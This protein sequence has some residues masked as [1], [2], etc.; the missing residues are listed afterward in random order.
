MNRKI[1]GS[2]LSL[3]MV[4]LILIRHAKSSWDFP[5]LDDMD[6]PLNQRGISNAFEI[7]NDLKKKGL[8]PDC[9]YCSPAKRT[10]S[11]IEKMSE[12]WTLRDLPVFIDEKLYH[13]SAEELLHFI[14]LLPNSQ[15]T[16]ALCGHNPGL[17]ELVPKLSN[18]AIDNFPTSGVM[19]LKMK[20]FPSAGDRNAE[21]RYFVYPKIL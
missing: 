6:R 10:L 18:L 16:V 11:T 5:H 7:A 21:L 20:N 19:V 9:V 14:R 3:K 2:L 13:A 12:I 17:T 1:K 4:N 15:L 8:M